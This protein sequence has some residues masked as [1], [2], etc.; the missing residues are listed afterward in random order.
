MLEFRVE[1]SSLQGTSVDAERLLCIKRIRALLR[2]MAGLEHWGKRSEAMTRFC[3]MDLNDM[4]QCDDRDI[5]FRLKES[6]ES[7]EKAS[8]WIGGI[9][10]AEVCIFGKNVIYPT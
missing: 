5:N 3:L 2:D 8:C 1:S 7:L 4:R 6:S 9:L 10:D